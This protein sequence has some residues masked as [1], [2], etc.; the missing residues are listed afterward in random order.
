MSDQLP[1]AVIGCGF[2]GSKHVRVVHQEPTLRVALA[3]DRREE[4]RRY[5]ESQYPGAP[6]A[7]DIEA[8]I[9][10]DAEGVIIASPISTHYELA[11]S[12]LL[13][14]KH[15][16]VE[17]PLTM[18]SVEC[19]ELI[20]LAESKGVTLMVGHTFEYHP[21]VR[22]LREIVDS[23]A[24]GEP[25]YA[26][27]RRL[28]LG[29]YQMDSNVLWDLAPHD[30][31]ILFHV[32]DGEI[33]TVEA[34]GCRHVIKNVEDVVYAKLGL[35]TGAMAHVHVSWLDPVKVRQFTLVG[36]DGMLVFDDS[37]P[38]EK[39]RVFDKRFKPTV[40]GDAFADFQN[41]YHHGNTVVPELQQGEPLRLEVLDFAA[42][43][44]TGSRPVA[45]GY[46]GLRVVEA[47]ERISE[48]LDPSAERRPAAGTLA[49]PELRDAALQNAVANVQQVTRN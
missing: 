17:K 28:N 4:R 14:G 13:A 5:I 30:L 25:Y 16:L 49:R 35:S 6:V 15:V 10:S 37:H 34:W 42:A 20:A 8:V 26:T 23:G 29:L 11:K 7:S 24:I 27:S 40:V 46:S 36:S 19:R 2:W 48:C 31:S 22:K 9:E 38:T 32:L 43:I 21:A 18:S 3:V 39:V 41:A 47:L 1:I 12:L 44:R 33:D 45:D